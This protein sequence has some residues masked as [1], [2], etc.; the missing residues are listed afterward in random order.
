MKFGGRTHYFLLFWCSI[1]TDRYVL[2]LLKG[3][4]IPFIND[5]PPIQHKIPQELKMTDEEMS[6]VDTHLEELLWDGFIK[7]LDNQIP[8]GLV[9]DIF[10]VPKHQGEFRMI[11]K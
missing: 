11:W 4:K 2:S 8:N 9:S 3:V 5:K 6:F 1:C 10:L 7:K